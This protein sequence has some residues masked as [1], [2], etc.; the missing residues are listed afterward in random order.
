MT[1]P[2]P[3]HIRLDAD[4]VA[5]NNGLGRIF[6]LP[7]SVARAKQIAEHFSDLT[8]HESPRQLNAYL[9]VLRRHGISLEVAAVPTGMGC[10]AMNIV[11]TELIGLGARRLLRERLLADDRFPD[12]IARELES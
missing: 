9:G 2:A 5:G 3:H 12:N 6:F 10:P 1:F 11:A 8:V 4:L 7:G